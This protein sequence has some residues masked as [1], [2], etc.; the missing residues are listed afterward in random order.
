[1]T[2]DTSGVSAAMFTSRIRSTS[3]YRTITQYANPAGTS[4][5]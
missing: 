1:V 5:S 4:P 3:N 2:S